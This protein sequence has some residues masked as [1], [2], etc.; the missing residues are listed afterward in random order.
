M[1]IKILKFYLVEG[2]W[3]GKKPKKVPSNYNEKIGWES[4]LNH[5]MYFKEVKRKK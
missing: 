2:E 1:D 3:L 5:R 4:N